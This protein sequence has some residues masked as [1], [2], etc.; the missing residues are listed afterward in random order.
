VK[1][2]DELFYMLAGTCAAIAAD[3]FWSGAVFGCVVWAAASVAAYETARFVRAKARKA[4][5]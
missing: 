5:A 2:V 3:W 1:D 4:K